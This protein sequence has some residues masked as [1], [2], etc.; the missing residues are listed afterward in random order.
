M[1][2]SGR[3]HLLE[4]FLSIHEALGFIL[5]THI[6]GVVVHA[7][8]PNTQE[9]ELGELEVVGHPCLHRE[10]EARLSYMRLCLNTTSQE[11]QPP[12]YETRKQTCQQ[13]DSKLLG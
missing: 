8:T 1:S 7:Y 9:V 13:F 3:A 2:C 10:F 11:W 4:L 6:L 12:K 5:S